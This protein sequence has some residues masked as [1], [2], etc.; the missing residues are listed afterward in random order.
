M[1]SACG[2]GG[3][4]KGPEDLIAWPLKNIWPERLEEMHPE[5]QET[6]KWVAVNEETIQWFPCTCGCVD[7]DDHHSNFDCYVAEQYDDG[8]ILLDQHSFG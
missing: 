2:F 5:I 7:T 3:S 6:Y 1:L 8:S 4:S